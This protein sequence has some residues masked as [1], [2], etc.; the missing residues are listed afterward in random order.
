[1]THKELEKNR[2]AFMDGKMTA[3]AYWESFSDYWSQF[4]EEKK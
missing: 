4:K 1:M 3:A 2:R